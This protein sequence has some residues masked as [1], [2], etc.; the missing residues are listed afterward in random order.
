MESVARAAGVSVASVSRVLNGSGLV[1]P[2]TAEKVRKAV[3]TLGYMPNH[4]AK[5]LK[6]RR[7]R[8]IA[9]AMEDIGNPVYVAMARAI[10]AEAKAEGYRVVLMSTDALAEDEVEVIRSLGQR[11]AD[12]LIICPI[13]ITPGHLRE[14]ARPAG[15]VV[16]IGSLPPDVAI[17]NVGV[18]SHRGALQAMEHLVGQGY[19]RIAFINGPSDTVPGGSRL[20]GYKA[21]LLNHGLQFDPSLV[22]S[23]NFQ[24]SGGYEAVS[25]LLALPSQPDA[26]FCAND[27]MALGAMRRLREAGL[28]VPGD[29]AIVG[30]DDIDQAGVAVPTLTSVSLGAAERGRLAARMLL[31]RLEGRGPQQPQRVTVIPRLVVRESSHNTGRS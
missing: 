28:A 15:P 24:I 8:Q 2:A 17:D 13:R 20:R 26:I 12:G 7:T 31:D 22:V 18:D 4:A 23:G 14:L 5:S 11:F 27:L 19:A 3:A 25:Q 9:F 29:V 1:S 10:Q 21:A 30:M 16:V 6:V